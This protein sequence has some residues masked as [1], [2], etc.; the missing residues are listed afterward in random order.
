[1][2]TVLMAVIIAAGATPQLRSPAA[3]RAK[4]EYDRAVAKAKAEYDKAV[5]AAGEKYAGVLHAEMLKATQAGE[6]DNALAYRQAK[7]AILNNGPPRP[8]GN[9]WWL[10]RFGNGVERLYCLEGNKSM[11]VETKDIRWGTCQHANGA[12]VSLCNDDRV[13]VIT[14]AGRSLR[15]LHYIGA[16]ISDARGTP[17]QTA[18]GKPWSLA[19]SLR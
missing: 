9:G 3:N 4:A 16:T 6:L 1:M 14:I 5:A 12:I 13:D 18:T 10:I 2:K 15:M 19:S 17:H 7:E 8:A 11:W